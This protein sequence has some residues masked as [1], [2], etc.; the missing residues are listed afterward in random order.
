MP[1]S[2]RG[3]V[4]LADLGMVAKVRPILVISVEPTVADRALVGVVPHTT[5]VRGTQF[6][7]AVPTAFLKPGAFNTQNIVTVP[8]T[9]LVKRLGRLSAAEVSDVIAALRK[10]LGIS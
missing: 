10:W 2:E 3:E 5:S 8:P 4:W 9:K 1:R 7:V 6:E